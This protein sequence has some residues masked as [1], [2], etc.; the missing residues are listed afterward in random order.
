MFLGTREEADEVLARVHR[1]H[2]TI[3]GTLPE[4][5]G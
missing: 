5:A 1:L 4:A 2:K 3:K